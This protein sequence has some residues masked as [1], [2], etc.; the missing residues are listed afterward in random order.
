MRLCVLCFPPFDRYIQ[1]DGGGV[2]GEGHNYGV[3]LNAII[4]VFWS[5]LQDF[6][7]FAASFIFVLS[8]WF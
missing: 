5:K 7:L 1:A 6:S 8:A 2:S 4:F 3:L